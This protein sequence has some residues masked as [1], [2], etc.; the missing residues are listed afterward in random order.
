[1]NKSHEEVIEQA[2]YDLLD[3]FLSPEKPIT[4]HEEANQAFET[5]NAIIVKKIQNA[6]RDDMKTK[7]D[8]L[9]SFIGDSK[10]IYNSEWFTKSNYKNLKSN[11]GYEK[12]IEL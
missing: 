4:T 5:I 8:K 1:M 9:L 6:K 10:R 3:L 2:K 7:R 11:A 12:E